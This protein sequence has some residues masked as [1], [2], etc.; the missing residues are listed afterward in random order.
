MN[1]FI[2]NSIRFILFL[3]I[4]VVIL[5]EVPP[6]HQFI[7]P[8]LY[9]LFILWLPFGINRLSITILGFILGF[10]LDLFSN[11][12][13][14]HAA[15][16]G[17]MAYIRPSILN[18]LLAQEASEEVHKEPSVG[19]MGWGPYLFYV[20]A[21][22]FIHHFYLVLLEWL[23]FGSFTYFLGKVIATTTMSVLLIFLVELIMNRRKLKR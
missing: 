17:L 18:L 9:F 4:Q 22:T 2:K 14:L 3:L 8:Y 20:F 5:K 23:E 11:T 21:L 6:V 12:P 7:T 1:S 13:G 15:A 16:C 19:T 10:V